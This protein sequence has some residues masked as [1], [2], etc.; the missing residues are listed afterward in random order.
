MAVKSEQ[1]EKN[2]VKLTF[3]VSREKFEEGINNSYK[4]KG[5]HPVYDKVDSV[6]PSNKNKNVI[7]RLYSCSLYT[8]TNVLSI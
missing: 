2:L 4:K 7:D 6:Y 1:V 5:A 8:T 3:E